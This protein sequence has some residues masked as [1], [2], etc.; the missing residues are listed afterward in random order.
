MV[1]AIPSRPLLRVVSETDLQKSLQAQAQKA[2]AEQQNT[3]EY[4][5]LAAFIR[6]SYG[7]F[8]RHRS[9][10]AGWSQRLLD[11]NRMFNGE[12]DP[13]KL[14]EI[15]RFGGSEVYARVIAMKCRGAFS[16]LRD[17]YLT[18]DRAWGIGPPADP[19]VPASIIQA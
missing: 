11:A 13:A 5:D 6:R 15:K 10:Q 4:D 7:E 16:L 18:Q 8:Q 14:Q 3:Q 1:S 12:Y 2:V 19:D 17:V 9:S